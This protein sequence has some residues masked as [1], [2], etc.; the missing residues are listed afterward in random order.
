MSD[1]GKERIMESYLIAIRSTS[2]P[3]IIL[4]TILNLAEF[5]E[6]DESTDAKLF[7]AHTLAKI[8]EQCDAYAK[9]L[10]YWELEFEKNDPR[11]TIELLIQTNYGLNQPEA[12]E[13]ILEYAKKNI[14]IDEKEDWYE[15]LHRWWDALRI[16]EEKL[17]QAPLEPE[18][19]KGKLKC[20]KNLSDW[21]TLA[22][23]VS[24]LWDQHELRSSEIA[25][26]E[27]GDPI[28][29][30]KE[31]ADMAA[32]ASWHLDD[33]QSFEKFTNYLDPTKQPYE[34]SFYQAVLSIKSG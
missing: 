6:L 31:V 9:A 20:L 24:Q 21:N 27:R 30:F 10:Y 7:T 26:S 3:T 19:F 1:K 14:L 13:G 5:M 8:A 32:Y 12:A 2:A 18:A 17:Q 15:K 28:E 29:D 33:Y 16:Y 34:L 4:Q 25:G 22:S 11:N 23:E